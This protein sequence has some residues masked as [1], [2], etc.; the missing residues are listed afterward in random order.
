MT[1]PV[2]GR[3]TQRNLCELGLGLFLRDNYVSVAMES[4]IVDKFK[5]FPRKRIQNYYSHISMNTQHS[6]R[7]NFLVSL[8]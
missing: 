8:L 3:D 6:G 1:C 5:I 2:D 7:H 4:H